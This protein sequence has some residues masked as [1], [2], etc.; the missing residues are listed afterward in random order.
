MGQVT[1]NGHRPRKRCFLLFFLSMLSGWGW[2]R[3]ERNLQNFT[4]AAWTGDGREGEARDI[5]GRGRETNPWPSLLC[6]SEKILFTTLLCFKI[7]IIQVCFPLFHAR[8]YGMILTFKIS[9]ESN[10]KLWFQFCVT[11]IAGKLDTGV[12]YNYIMK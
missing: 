3:G 2:G 10:I 11:E 7:N 9:S 5:F 12:D 6:Q 1:I 8:Y 4:L